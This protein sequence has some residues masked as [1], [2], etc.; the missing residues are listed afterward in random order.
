MNWILESYLEL[1]MGKPSV[2]P[3]V[4]FSYTYLYSYWNQ[5]LERKKLGKSARLGLAIF[6]CV[7]WRL[8]MQG[9][10]TFFEVRN[11]ATHALL[12]DAVINILDWRTSF[13]IHYNGIPQP[14]LR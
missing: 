9:A 12:I 3:V 14:V 5:E 8:I 2:G 4:P 13:P 7:W 10:L 1:S 6:K 11:E